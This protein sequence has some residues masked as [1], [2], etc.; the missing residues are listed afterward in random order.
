[1]TEIIQGTMAAIAIMPSLVFAFLSM[2]G[3]RSVDFLN[4]GARLWKRVIAPAVFVS[5]VLAIALTQHKFSWWMVTLYAS[6]F[7][8]G[9]IGYGADSVFTKLWR[10]SLWTIIR[11]CAALPL[12]IMTGSY[13]LWI[14]QLALGAATTLTLGVRNPLSA[15]AE[16]FL[17]NAISVILVPYMLF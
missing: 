15:P 2:A 1:M 7:I 5:L 4:V 13:T 10:R 11:S 16:E 9:M 14:L 8:S 12:C 17:I 3:G 6:Y